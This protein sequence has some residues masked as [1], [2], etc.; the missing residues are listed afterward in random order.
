[1][2]ITTMCVTAGEPIPIH[3]SPQ[4]REDK[5]DNPPEEDEVKRGVLRRMNTGKAAGAS[6]VAVEYL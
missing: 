4:H 1:M 5:N 3:I 2:D 6:G